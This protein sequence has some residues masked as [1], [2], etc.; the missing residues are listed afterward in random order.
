MEKV[1]TIKHNIIT[2]EVSYHTDDDLCNV[3]FLGVLE[4]VKALLMNEIIDKGIT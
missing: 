2:G 4:T 1:I 3:E